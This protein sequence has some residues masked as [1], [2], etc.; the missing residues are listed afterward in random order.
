MEERKFKKQ[1]PCSLESLF[2]SEHFLII[3]GKKEWGH[4]FAKNVFNT[5]KFSLNLF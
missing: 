2:F 3:T 5:G 1:T 4:G